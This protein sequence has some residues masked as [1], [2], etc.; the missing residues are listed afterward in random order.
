MG[1]IVPNGRF[2]EQ[3][4]LLALPPYPKPVAALFKWEFG[5][6]RPVIVDKANKSTF[7]IGIS[8]SGRP[9]LLL[10]EPGEFTSPNTDFRNEKDAREGNISQ[11]RGTFDRNA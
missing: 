4:S 7:R 11:K 1:C 8:K 5:T 9:S 3:G 6:P 10:A 2:G